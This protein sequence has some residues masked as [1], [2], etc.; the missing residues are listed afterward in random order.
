MYHFNL[1]DYLSIFLSFCADRDGGDPAVL[2]AGLQRSGRSGRHRAAGS[3]SVPHRDQAGR[4]AEKHTRKQQT[5]KYII[6]P[7]GFLKEIHRTSLCF[8][9]NTP[10]IV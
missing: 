6:F 5:L 8:I 2:P 4:H 9:R 1:E 7:A 3:G 10:R